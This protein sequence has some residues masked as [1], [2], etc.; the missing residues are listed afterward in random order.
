MKLIYTV[1]VMI[2]IVVHHDADYNAI[3]TYLAKS[4]DNM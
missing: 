1:I 2:C 4:S 3:E